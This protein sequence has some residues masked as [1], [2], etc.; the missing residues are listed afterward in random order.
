[1]KIQKNQL[2]KYLIFVFEEYKLKMEI[3]NEFKNQGIDY[4]AEPVPE[5]ILNILI[6]LKFL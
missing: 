3:V 2:V 5:N 1:M 4:F 6:G